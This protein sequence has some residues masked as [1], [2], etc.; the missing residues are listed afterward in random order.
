M[1]RT[2]FNRM[3]CLDTGN[4][5]N[6]QDIWSKIIYLLCYLF[7]GQTFEKGKVEAAW[8]DHVMQL[9]SSIWHVP[10]SSLWSKIVLLLL[11]YSSFNHSAKVITVTDFH[12]TILHLLVRLYF[13]VWL[14]QLFGSFSARELG[15]AKPVCYDH[16]LD[17]KMVVGYNSLLVRGC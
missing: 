4:E 8:C 2:C 9:M 13:W 11:N 6:H 5:K 12:S 14:D 17:T 7:I 15:V 1:E 3:Y 10:S 16:T